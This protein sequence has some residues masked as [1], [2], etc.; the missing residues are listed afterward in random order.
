MQEPID[1]IVWIEGG[2]VQFVTSSGS[3]DMVRVYIA[4][5]DNADGFPGEN[6][7]QGVVEFGNDL[8]AI[9]STCHMQEDT[10][11]FHEELARIDHAMHLEA[12][13]GPAD[14]PHYDS[15]G[16]LRP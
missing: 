8:W 7:E 5:A 3:E 9:G 1:V 11:Y 13:Y 14:Q 4:D 10:S 2:N 6:L 12:E 15:T 16:Y